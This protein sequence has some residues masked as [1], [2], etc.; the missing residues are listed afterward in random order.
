MCT[1]FL[2]GD[3]PSPDESGEGEQP[4]RP[5]DVAD[6]VGEVGAGHVERNEDSDGDQRCRSEAEEREPAP[7]DAAPE[8]GDDEARPG[9]RQEVAERLA[10]DRAQQRVGGLERVGVVAVGNA[11]NSISS[12]GRTEPRRPPTA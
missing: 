12:I 3:R 9:G 7:G 10:D 5:D 4:D 11:V 8:G 6:E 2:D 1:G